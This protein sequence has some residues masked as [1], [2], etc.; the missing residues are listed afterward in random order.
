M[1]G[2]C[3][4]EMVLGNKLFIGGISWDTSEE[5]L[6]EYFESYGAVEEAVIMRDRATG[7]CRGFGFVV[8]ADSAVVE[9]VVKEKHVIG[10]RTVSNR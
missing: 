6:R 1:I 4:M 3:V 8:F 5:R 7:R 2:N 10:G 9:R